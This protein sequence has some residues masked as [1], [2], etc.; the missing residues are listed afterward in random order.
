MDP[1]LLRMY[2]QEL[3]FVREL[4]G[5]FA[6]EFPKI[7]GRLGLDSFECADPYVE[8]LLEGFAFLAARVQ[9]KLE[10]EFPTFTQNL[11]DIVYPHFLA[12]TPSMVVVNFKPD[13]QGGKFE[14]GYPIPRD[15]AMFGILGK[16]D[17]TAC[18]F[19]T[20][21]DVTIWPVTLTEVEYLAGTAAVSALGLT[22]QRGAKAAIRLRLST[23]GQVPF[24]ALSLQSLTF[25]IRG[26]TTD[27]SATVLEQVLANPV[28]VAVRPPMRPV[29]WVD[30]LPKSQIRQVGLREEEALLPTGPRSFQGYRL[31]SEYFAFPERFLFFSLSDL[32]PSVRRT[33]GTELDIY[34]LLDRENKLLARGL[35]AENFLLN[36][37]P[38]INVFPKRLDRIHISE[39]TFEHHVIPDRS[40]PIDFEVFQLLNVAGQGVDLEREQEFL[41]FYARSDLTRDTD[42]GAYYTVRRLPRM[43]SAKQ[44]RTG[45]RTNYIG[46]EVYLSLVDAREAPYRAE[47]RQLSLRAFCTNR[48]LPMLMPTGK[49]KTDFTVEIGA[50]L[51][52]IRCIAGPTRPKPSRAH[53]DI[54][55]RL[56]SHLALNY[57]SITNAKD[58]AS[59]AGLREILSLYADSADVAIHKQ[60]E[61][62]KSVTSVPII[63]RLPGAGQTAIARGLE[64][65]VTFDET[66]FQGLGVFVLGMVLAQFFAKY[67]SINSFTETAIKTLDRGEVMRWP[68]MIGR[69]HTL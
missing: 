57:L 19:R 2:E 30:S 62:V 59:A 68:M 34:I 26:A 61:G 17:V 28:G 9:L 14:S 45:G 53:G 55:W 69:R 6:A 13:L 66:A 23:V 39:K 24:A 12:P 8:R 43:L 47:L 7:A 44:R 4:G 10:S 63:R 56:I 67:T 5:E 54:A 18:E 64:V 40:R 50:P 65:E 1:R 27:V 60:I 33:A 15:T 25:F 42:L 32:G 58:G 46:S 52:S 22:N 35:S 29:P 37:A 49:G 41:P 48:D 3:K 31:L 36:C 38:A 20:A 16:G 21:H 11:L 51:E